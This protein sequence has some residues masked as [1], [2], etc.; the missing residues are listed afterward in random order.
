MKVTFKYIKRVKKF[1]GTAQFKKLK[2]LSKIN[3]KRTILKDYVELAESSA[4][5]YKNG[6]KKKMFRELSK[7]LGFAVADMFDPTGI[8]A[9]AS[10]VAYPK[11]YKS[12]YYWINMD[13]YV[14]E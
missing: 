2:T 10:A 1:I 4:D 11:C 3:E 8:S 12:N 9:I 5:L 6:Q 14:D 7:F 13:K